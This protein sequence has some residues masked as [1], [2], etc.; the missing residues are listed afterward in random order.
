MSNV[1]TAAPGAIDD[2]EMLSNIVCTALRALL[3]YV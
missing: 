3:S 2:F 1:F